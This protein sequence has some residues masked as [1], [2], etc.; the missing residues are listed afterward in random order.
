M[1][2][3]CV[4]G[5]F[6]LFTSR[7][8]HCMVFSSYFLMLVHELGERQIDSHSSPFVPETSISMK[9]GHRD[10][11]GCQR[12]VP[13]GSVRGLHGLFKGDQPND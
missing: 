1:V 4:T 6:A 8:G 3:T 12:A 13:I 7:K 5:V 11:T 9:F 2:P 10:V